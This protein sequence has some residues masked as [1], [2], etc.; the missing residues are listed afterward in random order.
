MG[1]QTLAQFSQLI[2]KRSLNRKAELSNLSLAQQ[3]C[4][5]LASILDKRQVLISG[6]DLSNNPI[7]DYGLSLL[8]RPICDYRQLVSLNLA[9]C[10]LTV[11][12]SAFLLLKLLRNNQSLLFLE[13]GAPSATSSNRIGKDF[14]QGLFY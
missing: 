12:G 8:I 6:L 4:A 10:G 14:C 5:C 7:G 2:Q 1:T 13:L 11:R 9:G 3:S